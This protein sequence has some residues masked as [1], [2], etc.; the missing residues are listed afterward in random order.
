MPNKGENIKNKKLR[1]F[2]EGVKRAIKLKLVT[3]C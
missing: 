1:V 2:I 3:I